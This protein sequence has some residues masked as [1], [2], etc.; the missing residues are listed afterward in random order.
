[1][2]V[3]T[4]GVSLR[5]KE[6]LSV[7]LYLSFGNLLASSLHLCLPGNKTRKHIFPPALRSHC[8]CAGNLPPDPQRFTHMLEQKGFGGGGWERCKWW[9]K[10]PGDKTSRR[11]IKWGKDV[12]GCLFRRLLDSDWTFL[13]FI[14]PSGE[15]R[16]DRSCHPGVSYLSLS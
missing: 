9:E 6:V 14:G 4:V 10:L 1:M 2:V 7:K 11:E 15:K 3:K 16:E 8:Q 5:N 12:T 13:T